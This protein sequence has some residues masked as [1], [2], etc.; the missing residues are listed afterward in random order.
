MKASE[1]SGPFMMKSPIDPLKV[2]KALK[3]FQEEY[4]KKANK[5]SKEDKIKLQKQAYD[6]FGGID[7]KFYSNKHKV[8]VDAGDGVL[9][10]IPSQPEKYKKI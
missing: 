2:G 7:G 8:F 4:S 10:N 6:N 5:V 1:F 3:D 9:I